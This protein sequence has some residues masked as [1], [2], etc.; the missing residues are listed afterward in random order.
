M[1][2]EGLHGVLYEVVAKSDAP[3]EGA[4]MQFTAHSITLDNQRRTIEEVPPLAD[5]GRCLSFVRAFSSI[6]KD[7]DKGNMRIADL[8]CLEGG[9]AVELARQGY[10]VLGVEAKSENFKKCLYVQENVELPNLSFVQDDVRHLERYGPFDAI[11]CFGILY[12]LDDPFAFLKT[13]GR[14]TRKALIALCV[15]KSG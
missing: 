6:F 11:L 13:L 15:T 14:I 10:E 5:G 9:Y 12:H 8:G 7:E 4:S 2:H 3:D 1:Y